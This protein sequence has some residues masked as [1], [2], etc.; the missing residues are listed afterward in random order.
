MAEEDELDVQR[1]VYELEDRRQAALRAGDREA[2]SQLLS[3]DFLQVHAHGLIEGK[4]AFLTAA[5]A[6]PGTADSSRP[7]LSI[8]G[9]VALLR[10]LVVRRVLVDG[11]E[12]AFRIFVTRVAAQESGF[13]RYIHIQATMVPEA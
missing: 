1:A 2:L 6:Y 5:T 7:E 13:W 8:Y 12:R 4:E 10:G 11:T 3:D 9:N